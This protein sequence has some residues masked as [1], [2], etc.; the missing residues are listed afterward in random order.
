MAAPNPY[1]VAAQWAKATAIVCQ[2]EYD[3]HA[4]ADQYTGDFVTANDVYNTLVS[5]T[6]E[7]WHALTV[8]AGV[9][10]SSNDVHDIALQIASI[11][12]SIE[13]RQHEIL[14][15]VDLLEKS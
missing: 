6:V 13:E 4:L 8:R 12:V 1:K 15:P 11:K 5:L 3:I 10:P 2:L 9:D 14:T 7:R